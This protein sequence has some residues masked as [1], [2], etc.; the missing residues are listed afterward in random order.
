MLYPNFILL[1]AVLFF[2]CKSADTKSNETTTK[3]TPVA[4]A[5]SKPASVSI[6]ETPKEAA[7]ASGEGFHGKEVP[8]LCYHQL[9]D[10]KPTDSK[11]SRVYIMPM[12]VFKEELK[13]LHDSG[14]TSILPDQLM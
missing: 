1:L 14:Y 5:E 13:A 4:Q 8:I 10:W 6:A 9:R 12:E 7:P 2:S 3:D 11:S